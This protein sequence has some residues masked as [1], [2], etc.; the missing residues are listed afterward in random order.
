MRIGKTIK[1]EREK[2]ISESERMMSRKK[3]EK[4]KKFSIAIFFVILALIIVITIG[5]IVTGLYKHKK[6]ETTPTETVKY[7]PTVEI[8]DEGGTGYV[9]DKIKEFVGMAEAD[10]KDYGYKVIKAIVPAGKTR[11]V[12][13]YLEGRTEFYKCQIDRSAAETA[14]DATRMIKYLDERGKTASYVDV[15]IAGRAYYK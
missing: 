14:E 1:G 7:T 3:E 2:A 9:T 12:D 5:I 8:V 6:A 4:R 15:R 13:I 11:E 10:F